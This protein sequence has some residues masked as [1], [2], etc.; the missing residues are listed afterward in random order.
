M[1]NY[2]P[3]KTSLVYGDETT[4]IF[5]RDYIIEK[6]GDVSFKLSARAFFR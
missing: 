3:G 4:R 2:N 6:L 5:G 1:Q